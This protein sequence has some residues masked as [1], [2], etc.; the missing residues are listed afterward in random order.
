[1]KSLHPRW[2]LLLILICPPAAPAAPSAAELAELF[3]PPQ[4]T[5]PKLSPNGEYLGFMA[6]QGDIHAIGV[7]SFATRKMEFKGG[8]TKIIP[9]DFWWKTPTRLLV[10]T[11]SDKR[12]AYGYTAF[13]ADG[14][15][16]EDV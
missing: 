1:M 10:R 13:D 15:N 6:R 7:Y 4:F 11:T 12:D 2:L 16:M 8:S 9:L 14:K 3:L 5:R